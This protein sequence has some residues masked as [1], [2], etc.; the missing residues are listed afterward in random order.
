MVAGSTNYWKIAKLLRR[1]F[2]RYRLRLPFMR[3]PY[4]VALA[5]GP[6]YG[7]P[8]IWSGQLRP[9]EA[10]GLLESHRTARQVWSLVSQMSSV[11]REVSTHVLGT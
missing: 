2:A 8:A 4:I 6:M 1:L 3:A 11:C 7:A 10:L 5:L 9:S